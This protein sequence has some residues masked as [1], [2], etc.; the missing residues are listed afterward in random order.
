LEIATRAW[1]LKNIECHHSHE[2]LLSLAWV[3]FR[4]QAILDRLFRSTGCNSKIVFGVRNVCILLYPT[5]LTYTC[6]VCPNDCPNGACSIDGKCQCSQGYYGPDCSIREENNLYNGTI[7]PDGNLHIAYA[8][9]DCK[10]LVRIVDV[11]NGSDLISSRMCTPPA[12]LAL[13]TITTT[14]LQISRTQSTETN[15]TRSSTLTT[16]PSRQVVAPQSTRTVTWLTRNL[17]KS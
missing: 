7:F 12:L 1:K 10:V 3:L 9:N 4:V 6:V 5:V 11:H 16:P 14:I 17:I 13:C 15:T 2:Q 8:T